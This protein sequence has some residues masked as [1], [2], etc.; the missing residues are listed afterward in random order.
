MWM[1]ALGILLLLWQGLQDMY[2]VQILKIGEKEQRSTV[3]GQMD[4]RR[5]CQYITPDSKSYTIKI[6]IR[7]Q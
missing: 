5:D 4:I 2:L 6:H 7:E 3:F 1:D